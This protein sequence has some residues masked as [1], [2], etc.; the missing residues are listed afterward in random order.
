MD[1]SDMLDFCL[2]RLEGEACQHIECAMACDPVFAERVCRLSR[3]VHL[4]LDDEWDDGVMARTLIALEPRSRGL[5]MSAHAEA[6][7]R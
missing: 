7:R 1:P 3:C 4:L 5:V 2:G 6:P